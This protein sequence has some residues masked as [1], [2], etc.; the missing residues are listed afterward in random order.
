M[1]SRHKRRCPHCGASM[2]E[3]RHTLS[4]A[5]VEA[6]DRLS[7]HPGPVNIKILGLTRNQWDNFQKLRYWGLVVKSHRGNGERIGGHWQ[8]TAAGWRF[9]GGNAR[10]PRSVWTYRGEWV[11]SD[12]QLVRVQDVHAR[13]KTRP[14]YAAEARPHRPDDDPSFRW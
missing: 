6:L 14:E 3:H 10:V 5:M 9:L 4:V 2:M 7:R 8:I 1:S 13:Y 11:R 12:E